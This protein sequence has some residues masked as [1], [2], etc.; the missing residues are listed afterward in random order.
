MSAD[1]RRVKE[2][3][4]A[5]LDLPDAPARKA[6]LDRECSD[7]P[8]LRNR[9]EVL[10]S[11]HNQ[12]ES[13]LERPLAIQAEPAT[14]TFGP[15]SETIGTVIADRYKLLEEIGEGG[16]GTVWMAQQ[17]EPVKRT[18]AVKLIKPGM[19]SRAVLA[20]FEAER[21]ALA[22]MD[23]PGIAKVL[24]GGVTPDGRPFFVMELVKGTPLTR[25]CD[26]R[27]LTPHERLGLFVPVCQAVQHAHQKGVIHRDLKPSNV[28]VALYDDKPVPKIIDFGVAKATGQQLTEETLHTGFGAVVGTVEYM[29]PEQATFNQLDIDTRSDIYSLGV[30]LYELLAGSPPFTKNELEKAGMLEMLRVIREQEPS[31]PSAKLSTADG[32]PTLAANRG[33]EPAK[34]TR[35]VRGELDWIVMKALEKDR[36]R[37]YETANGFAMDVQRYLADEQVLACPPSAA[38]RLRKF[39]R[40][41]KGGLTVAALVLFFLMLLGSGAGWMVRNREARQARAGGQIELILTEVDQLEKE[42]KWPE[43]LAAARRAEAV[44]AGGGADPATE[45]RVRERLKDLEF[46]DRLEQIRMQQ[47]TLFG[48]DFDHAGADREYHRAFREYGVDVEAQAVEA[49][50]ER[51]RMR[52]ALAMPLAAALDDWALARWSS[53][54]DAAAKRLVAVARAIDPEPLRD[55]FRAT[56]FKPASEGGDELGRLA[57]SIDIRAHLPTTLQLLA[58]KL[59]W[60]NYPDAALRL[61]RDA[62]RAHPG[63]FWLNAT[64]AYQLLGR[65]DFEGAVRFYTAAV[66]ARPWATAA[67]TNLGNALS[68]QKKLDEAIAVYHRALEIDP[69]YANAHLNKGVTLEKQGKRDEAIAC[70]QKAIELDPKYAPAHASLGNA[71]REQK[72]LDEAIKCFHKAIELDPNYALAH[73]CLGVTLQR[74]G[75]LDGAIACHKKA[76]KLAPNSPTSAKCHSHLGSALLAQKKLGEAVAAF[77]EAI[78]LDPTSA[79][80]QFGL[81]NALAQQKKWPEAIAAF[82]KA[83]ELDPTFAHAHVNLGISLRDHLKEYDKAIECFRKGIELDPNLLWAHTCLGNALREQ[84]KLD[85]AIK[86]FHKAIELDP[87]FALAHNDLAWLLATAPDAKVRN[88]ARSVEL[89]KRAVELAP[90]EGEFWNTLGA[91]HYRAGDW[92]AAIAAFEKSM[93]LGQGGNSFDWFFLAMAHWQLGEKDKAREWYDRAVAWM[94][95]NQ[96]ENEDFR[97]FRAEAAQLMNLEEKKD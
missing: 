38:Y 65:K 68:D 2:L 35:L 87:K 63:D 23:H 20:R 3:F 84:K 58:T 53:R 7:D 95:K 76:I 73:T 1:P 78:K 27:R 36:N 11:A 81:G 47:T 44:V 22:L 14:D 64:L 4:G 74:Q 17:T 40:R 10:L 18:V 21:Q 57:E 31:K 5:A 6:L 56:W 15:R 49:A 62:Q 24:D 41:N 86:C 16:M 96:P 45:R 69:K 91:A 72:H 77:G 71:L 26:E 60:A 8:E 37:R 48:R 93:K 80:P 54:R 94:D 79:Q 51:L 39:A 92:K 32:L 42:Q 89:A 29:S 50:V 67:L 13:V 52:P 28:L 25:Y 90:Q 59:E 85:E 61:R 66:A 82:H 9:V 43:A 70:Y 88:P 33:T 30:L 12:P 75:K 83:I 34:L 19:D 97:R 46:I 55:R